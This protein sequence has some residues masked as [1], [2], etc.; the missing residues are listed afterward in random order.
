MQKQK[1]EQKLRDERAKLYAERKLIIAQLDL[2]KLKREKKRL[3]KL[4]AQDSKKMS[5][6]E[7]DIQNLSLSN[8]SDNDLNDMLCENELTYRNTFSL[9]PAEVEPLLASSG[10]YLINIIIVLYFKVKYCSF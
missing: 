10:Q 3:E 8:L 7:D 6:L 1:Y 4:K 9:Y 2:K 5:V